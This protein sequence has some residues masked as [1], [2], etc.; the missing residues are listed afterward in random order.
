MISRRTFLLLTTATL[1]K[2]ALSLS[3]EGTPGL[4]DHILLGCSDL[5]AGIAFVEEHTGVR[6]AFGG[7][8]PGRATRHALVSLG[9]RRYLEVIAPD[10]KQESE[11]SHAPGEL[12]KLKELQTP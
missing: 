8:H 2:P 5:D 6:P 10:P 4:L 12:A 11:Q 7:V 9:E 3:T 1:L